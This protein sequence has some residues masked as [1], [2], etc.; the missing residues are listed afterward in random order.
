MGP[1]T[2]VK[3]EVFGR[4]F[5][6]IMYDS[7]RTALQWIKIRLVTISIQHFDPPSS[8]RWLKG[9]T[10]TATLTL[11]LIFI[12]IFLKAVSEAK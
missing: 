3:G 12:I 4:I 7:C 1:K 2:V 9:R 10:L 6:K 11:I 5:S 8:S